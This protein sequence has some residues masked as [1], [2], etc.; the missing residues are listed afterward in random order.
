MLLNTVTAALAC[1]SLPV[2]GAHATG[3]KSRRDCKQLSLPELAMR[4][5][6]SQGSPVFGHYQS[7]KS[8][9][10]EWMKAHPDST[11][12]VH[13]NIPGAH[14]AQTWNYSQATREQLLHINEIG[15]KIP[16]SSDT[17]RCQERSVV[18]SE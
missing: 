9:T 15:G 6:L 10:S 12:L 7:V 14:D 3:L 13:M 1:L 8:N 4:E 5:I 2:V 16:R 11:L 17:Y 18:D